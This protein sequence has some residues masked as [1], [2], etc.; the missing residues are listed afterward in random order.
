M[1]RSILAVAGLILVLA[2]A[3]TVAAPSFAH[4]GQAVWLQA[5]TG[6]RAASAK[7]SLFLSLVALGATFFLAGLALRQ[8]L[9]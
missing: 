9:K 3:M 4:S 2:A 6:A 5:A 1:R 7:I 8:L